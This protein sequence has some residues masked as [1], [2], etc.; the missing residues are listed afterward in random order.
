MLH[1]APWIALSLLCHTLFAPSLTGAAAP[2]PNNPFA[3]FLGNYRVIDVECLRD[4]Y[5]WRDCALL[6][7]NVT[8]NGEQIELQENYDD[9]AEVISPIEFVKK[10]PDGIETS[11]R[12]SGDGKNEALWEKFIL[13][14]KTGI[15]EL[16]DLRLF[17]R[18]VSPAGE[19]LS[20]QI[21]WRDV[22][23][24]GEYQIRKANYKL[25]RYGTP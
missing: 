6:R 18:E 11:A 8:R 14:R 10:N 24:N 1:R 13:N 25:M 19:V 23:V 16:T 15:R 4:G 20:Y 21:Y 2:F 22:P 7:L 17:S 3:G 9:F 5:P 12:L